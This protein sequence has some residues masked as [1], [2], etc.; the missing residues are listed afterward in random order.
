MQKTKK[1]ILALA[2]LVGLSG[3]ANV[4]SGV[5]GAVSGEGF[6][7]TREAD[8]SAPVNRGSGFLGLSKT[9]DQD[10]STGRFIKGQSVI[11]V[12]FFNVSYLKEDSF[13]SESASTNVDATL[14][15]ANDAV[16]QGITDSAYNDL[17]KKLKN[18]GFKVASL[19]TLAASPAYQD[20]S[21][22]QPDRD[23]EAYGTIAANTKEGKTGI[24]GSSITKLSKEQN[25]IPM[26]DVNY[27]THFAYSQTGG[28][29]T[30]SRRDTAAKAVINI[31][32]GATIAGFAA[33]ATLQGDYKFGQNP[34]SKKDPGEF[35][36]ET[37]NGQ[38]AF[39]L[40]KTWML[41]GR[42]KNA[43]VK[44]KTTD[45]IYKAA[46]LEAL[47]NANTKLVAHLKSKR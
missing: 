40:A 17:T 30:F 19:S 14:I 37:S 11:G 43:D 32:G 38:V 29:F 41:G 39:D 5:V 34:Y 33:G 9:K 31:E 1:T 24:F 12:P 28:G 36:N 2:L 4:A 45:K 20:L 6:E 7:G 3:C 18:A 13:R 23:D 15:G 8:G 47:Y 35:I 42:D 46:A 27:I 21:S 16:F 10:Q 26:L 25:N 44:I 22:E